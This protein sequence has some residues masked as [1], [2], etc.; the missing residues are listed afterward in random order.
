MVIEGLISVLLDFVGFEFCEIFV[1]NDYMLGIWEKLFLGVWGEGFEFYKYDGVG[2]VFGVFFY[3]MLGVEL[4]DLILGCLLF[5]EMFFYWI[6]GVLFMDFFVVG[7]VWIGMGVIGVFYC[8]LEVV[9][10]ILVGDC[11][12]IVVD[13]LL[14]S[15][16][17]VVV[18]IL[19]LVVL[20]LS[21]FW[22]DYWL[23]YVLLGNGLVF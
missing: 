21:I 22:K 10:V 14:V 12:F 6:I 5:C 15:G 3:G 9:L 8:I 7:I 4:L 19:L 18:W 13:G 23:L 16:D 11:L 1:W 2:E 17:F 20:V